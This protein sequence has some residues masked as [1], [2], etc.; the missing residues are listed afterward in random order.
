M[1]D[2]YEFYAFSALME[3]VSCGNTEDL[4]VQVP[5][6]ASVKPFNN[7]DLQAKFSAVCAQ[8]AFLLRD[9]P[10]RAR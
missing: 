7:N 4:K 1:P 3:S 5:P 6:S 9:I 2:F 10:F 8:S